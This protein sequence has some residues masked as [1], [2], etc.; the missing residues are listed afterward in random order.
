MQKKLTI[1]G[2]GIAGLSAGIYARLN[3]FETEILEMH[4][5][6][7][8]QCTAWERKGYHFD[9]CLRWL[10][11]TRIGP[12]HD[13]WLET[14]ALNDQVEVIDHEIHTKMFSGDGIEFNLYTDLAKW[15]EYLLAIA[16]EDANSIRIMCND[17]RKSSAVR[18]FTDAPNSRK[19]IDNI[20]Q[21]IQNLPVILLYLRFGRKS[22]K[23]YF[24]K[25]NF[26]NTKLKYFFNNLYATHDYSALAFIM[27]LAWFNQKNAGYVK[28]GSLPIAARMTKRFL[29][30]GG[31]LST[32]TKVDK[33]IVKNDSA[34]GVRL[35]EGS[36]IMSD[37]VISAADGHSTIFEM[38][39]GNFLTKSISNAYK[40][41]D[42]FN[43][44]VQVSFGINKEIKS[45]FSVQ[46]WLIKDI[47]I[48]MTRLDHGYSIMNYHFDNTMAPAGKT[49]IT[50]RFVSP[51]D[52]WK[53]LESEEYKSEKIIIKKDAGRILERHFPGITENIEIVDVATP[54]TGVRHTG[55]WKGAYEGFLPSSKNLNSSLKATL[56]GLKQFYMAGQWLFPGGGLPPSGQSGKWAIQ[57][58][59][60]K[61]KKKFLTS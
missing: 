6:A 50:I 2:G 20:K 4:S 52:L 28:G 51:W 32:G 55:V 17:M 11:G 36:E 41:W 39:D 10:V 46:T 43:P 9:Y 14:D 23:Q 13:I 29:D 16:P 31:T 49:V 47:N 53:G 3:G 35:S 19:L 8:G 38:L 61:E 26:T 54:R 22:C 33:I 34:V 56:P 1:I 44:I 42:V 21:L 12:F 27:M 15:R 24:E 30:L 58:I 59:C 25:L 60:K 7:G 57:M 37:Y 40:T 48:G 45:D 18:P 5:V